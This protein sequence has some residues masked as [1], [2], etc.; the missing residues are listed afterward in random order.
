MLKE[1]GEL[2]VALVRAGRV[3]AEKD[4]D[5]ALGPPAGLCGFLRHHSAVWAGPGSLLKGE[6]KVYFD[7]NGSS[8]SLLV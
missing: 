2:C 8:L 4:K 6:E 1:G 7:R 5:F 3:W